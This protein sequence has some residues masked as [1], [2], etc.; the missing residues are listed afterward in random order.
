MK[1]REAQQPPFLVCKQF[2]DMGDG[3]ID[4]LAETPVCHIIE[5]HVLVIMTDVG[6]GASEDGGYTFPQPPSHLGAGQGT[7]GIEIK[8][9]EDEHLPEEELFLHP[10]AI[11]HEHV[12]YV[13]DHRQIGHGRF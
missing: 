2:L 3:A 6:A 4:M 13:A 1:G 8:D 10:I 12:E 7:W 5:A 11:V 9:D